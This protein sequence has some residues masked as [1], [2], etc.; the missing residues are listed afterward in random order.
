MPFRFGVV[1]LTEAPQCFVRAR[2]ERPDGQAH[3][4]AAAE[5]L[6][7]KWFDKDLKLSN[8]DNFDQLRLSLRLA[9]DAYLQSGRPRTAFAHFAGH[10]SSSRVRGSRSTFS[11]TVPKRRVVW[12]MS[13]SYIGDRRM[14]LA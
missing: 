10:W 14:V 9:A 11:R 3:W 5:L 2:I 7:P 8:D 13:G 4:G 6:A 1:T 12:K